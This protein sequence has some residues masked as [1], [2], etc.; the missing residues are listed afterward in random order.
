MIYNF[1]ETMQARGEW[2]EIFSVKRKNPPAYS[3]YFVKYPLKMKE[4]LGLHASAAG[5]PGST[6]GVA[7]GTEILQA[8]SCSQKKKRQRNKDI[9]CH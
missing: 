6:P 5:G 2:S 9:F 1:S 4:W 7:G 3:L 8:A